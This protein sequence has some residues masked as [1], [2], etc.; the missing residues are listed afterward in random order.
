MTKLINVKLQE[1]HE[2]KRDYLRYK[3]RDGRHHFLDTKEMPDSDTNS[4]TYGQ[5]VEMRTAALLEPGMLYRITDYATTTVQENTRSAGH[6][7]DVVVMALDSKTLA[8]R[9]WAMPH[10]GDEYFKDSKLEAWQL[11][12]CLD[13]DTDRFAWADDENGKGVIY[14]MI[15]EWNNDCPYDF[16]NIQ[17]KRALTDGEYDPDEGED[18]WCYTFTWIDEDDEAQDA[19]VLC[20]NI[21][22]DEGFVYGVHDNSMLP[23]IEYDFYP[24]EHSDK[25]AFALNDNVFISS[26]EYEG[27]VFYGIYGNHFGSSCYSNTFGNN[28]GGNTFGNYCDGNTFGN[29]CYN[30]SFGNDCY[31]NTFGNGCSGNTFGNYCYNNSFGN[32]CFGNTFGNNNYRNTFGNDCGNNKFGNNFLSSSIGDYVNNVKVNKDYVQFILI[33]NGNQNITITSSATTSDTFRIQNFA[34]ALGVN[35]GGAVKTISHNSTNNTFKTTYQNA[36]SDVVDV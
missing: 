2:G 21:G 9:A 30:N 27:G 7:F 12:Y 20:Q 14:R 23:C 15:D 34:I 32:Y 29:Y 3:G 8:E 17:F 19:S 36:N 11:W 18:V 35:N 25:L 13:N 22:G 5:L 6:N 10:E 26:Y 28:C 4:V 31:Y 1:I 16:K 33:E 24:E